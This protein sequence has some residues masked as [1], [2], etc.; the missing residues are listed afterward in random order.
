MRGVQHAEL[1]WDGSDASEFD[2]L[3]DGE[4][5]ATVSGSSYTDA[6]GNRGGGSYE[7]QVC[8]AGTDICSNEVAVTF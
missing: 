6:I 2:V 3:R 1:A 7:Y 8:E 4:T 5:I